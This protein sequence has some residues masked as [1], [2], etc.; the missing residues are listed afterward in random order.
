LLP[1]RHA[2][3]FK[4]ALSTVQASLSSPH[5]V[6]RHVRDEFRLAPPS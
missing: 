6:E 3:P 4:P 5:D 2:K 1:T